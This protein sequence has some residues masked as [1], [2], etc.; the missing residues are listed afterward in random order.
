MDPES[1]FDYRTNVSVN[2]VRLDRPDIKISLL[3]KVLKNARISLLSK[4]CIHQ[5]KHSL[6]SLKYRHIRAFSY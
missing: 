2:F 4:K 1:G 5:I 6:I 3:R